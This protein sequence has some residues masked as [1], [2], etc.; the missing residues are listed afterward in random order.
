MNQ[1]WST[2]STSFHIEEKNWFERYKQLSKDEPHHV[3]LESGRNGTYS[4]IGLHPFAIISGKGNTLTIEQ[5][6]KTSTKQG[7]LLQLMKE[8]LT[9]Y[10]TDYVEG[11]PPFQ[12]G[13]IGYLSYDIV[14]EF[15]KLPIEA[16]DDLGIPELYF[17]L[18]HEVFVYEHQAEKMWVVVTGKE[19]EKA[20]LQ[21]Q[22]AFYEQEWQ[23]LG[24]FR[25][26]VMTGDLT[27]DRPV[28][29]SLN[30]EKF[31]E[32][33]E[34]I[35]AY[36]AAGDVFQVNLSV[37]H[38]QEMVTEPMHVYNVLREINPS[39]YMSYFQTPNFQFVS[40]SPELL[41]KKHYQEISTRPIA[42]TRSR[43]KD[44]EEDQRLVNELL[45]NE[46]ERAEHV[47]LVDLERNDLG[48][49]SE[50]GSVEVNELLVIE[51]Y[52]HV[53]HL[54]SNV[55]GK[56]R[57]GHDLYEVI[58]ATFPGG[59]I[60][61][62]PKIRTMEIIEELEPVRRAVYTGSIGWI[63]FNDE[64]ELNITIRTIV[65][66]DNK[67]YI[68]AGAGIVIDSN[69]VFEYKESLKKAKALWRALELSEA[70]LRRKKV[71]MS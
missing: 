47:M 67:A 58:R 11:L 49:V 34:K 40:A 62:A 32:A 56:L 25:P 4:I 54:V 21:E 38:D 27:K 8:E 10:Q 55:R 42:G 16:E 60:T 19:E 43:G 44:E 63:G 68:Q 28:S 48:R 6:G 50:Y 17:M 65:C 66:K 71:Q 41:V 23:K 57:E 2:S 24:S 5:D 12:G 33:V 37:R 61:G 35:K 64:M 26:W 14:R 22:V 70:E 9:P 69:P 15:E 59:T 7:E 20:K 36:I 39:P 29:S 53:M 13:A 45:A 52:S 46:K 18:F 3:L 31:A 30:E 1:K 51:K